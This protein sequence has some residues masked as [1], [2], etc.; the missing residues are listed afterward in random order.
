M[1]KNNINIGNGASNFG[2]STSAGARV[3]TEEYVRRMESA[4]QR[5]TVAMRT[6]K[7]EL[8]RYRSECDRLRGAHGQL[9][10]ESKAK[11]EVIAGLRLQLEESNSKIGSG[12]ISNHNNFDRISGSAT[13]NLSLPKKS[14]SGSR[15]RGKTTD[16]LMESKTKRYLLL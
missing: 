15:S 16:D 5:A 8:E 11:E 7:E 12:F 4:V 13:Q 6:M 1:R 9:I 14:K 3:S 10:A 2:S